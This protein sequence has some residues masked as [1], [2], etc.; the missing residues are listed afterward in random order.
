MVPLPSD[1]FLLK[2]VAHGA[3]NPLTVEDAVAL[4]DHSEAATEIIV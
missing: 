3:A 4:P 2:P 1:A